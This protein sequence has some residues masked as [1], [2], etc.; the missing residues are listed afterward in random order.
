MIFFK[1]II[2]IRVGVINFF[3]LRFQ[4]D[5]LKNIYLDSTGRIKNKYMGRKKNRVENKVIKG[6]DSK[7]KKVQNRIDF[8]KSTFEG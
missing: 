1:V 7:T 8:L 2:Q 4:A 6:K 5:G 3:F